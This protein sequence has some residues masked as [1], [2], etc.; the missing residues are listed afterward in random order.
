MNQLASSR[1][2]L[3]LIG[4][5]MICAAVSFHV[6]HRGEPIQSF[7]SQQTNIQSTHLL[8]R[9]NMQAPFRRPSKPSKGT[10]WISSEKTSK[11]T[12]I[13]IKTNIDANGWIRIHVVISCITA[14]PE[15]F[16]FVSMLLLGRRFNRWLIRWTPSKKMVYFFAYKSNGRKPFL[17]LLRNIVFDDSRLYILSENTAELVW[18]RGR[19]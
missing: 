18:R 13:S 7:G 17:F 8:T 11:N 16:I 15:L 2:I 12:L 14:I 19:R 10:G 3:F 9:R 5:F 1:A 4:G 6:N